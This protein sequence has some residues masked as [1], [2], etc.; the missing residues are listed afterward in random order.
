MFQ[1]RSILDLFLAAA[2]FVAAF[3]LYWFAF[4]Y[5][6]ANTSLVSEPGALFWSCVLMMIAF[7]VFGLAFTYRAVTGKRLL[8]LG[9]IG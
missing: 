3:A 9:L 2:F 4:N 8:G 1:Q 6:P 7:V 5:R